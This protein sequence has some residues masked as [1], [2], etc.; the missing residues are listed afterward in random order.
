MDEDSIFVKNLLIKIVMYLV[1]SLSLIIGTL[2]TWRVT[3]SW[4]STGVAAL[5]V[6]STYFIIWVAINYEKPKK[7]KPY[8]S[9]ET[10]RTI[11]PM[12]MDRY[13]WDTEAARQARMANI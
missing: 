1:G 12:E 2:E 10:E 5:L 8:I 4:E 9:I 13:N 6:L 11:D 3:G 7:R